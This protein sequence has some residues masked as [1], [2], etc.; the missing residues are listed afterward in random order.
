MNIRFYNGKILRTK[1][2]H[3][4][5]I[6]EGE[7]WVK[8]NKI[9]YLGDGKDLDG[10]YQR[11]DEPFIIW[12]REIDAR[13]YVI[14]PG[15]KN[16]HTHSAMTFLRSFADDMPLKDWLYNQIFPREAKLMPGDIRH[17]CKLG[18][19]EYLTSGIT[20]NFDMYLNPMEI[21][22]ASAECGFRTVQT[23]GLNDFTRSL[24][25]L[26]EDYRIVNEMSE[27]TTFLLGFHG[28]YTTRREL[29]EG[30]AKLAEKLKSPVWLH[31]SE[32]EKE[33]KECRGRYGMTP[34][35]ITEALG[36]YAFGGGGY[37]CI[38]FEEKDFEIFRNRG[39][40]AVTNPSSNLKLASGTAPTAR[41]LEEGISMAIGTDGPASNNA[42][43]MFREMFLVTGLAKVRERDAAAV[44]AEEV[45]YMATAGGA[46][47]M[48][49]SDCDSLEEGKFADLILID[50][51]QPNMQPENDFVKN[52]VY[53]GSKSNVALTM[54][55]GRILYEKGEF[56]I[57]IDPK[58]VYAK[59]NE[60]IGRMK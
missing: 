43:D 23:S 60:I 30:V 48:E 44:P 12:D 38:Y 33:V 41:F 21:A 20:A 18:I 13:G 59:A 28:E 26:E 14:M 11:L 16:A 42:L 29:M 53:S 27:L 10:V 58:E 8:G 32:T 31:N 17:L 7:L 50:L 35:Q 55:N 57:G 3:S 5:E 24:S 45:L 25:L 36:M 9:V 34:T 40:T 49:L 2:N 6:S 4:F 19:M 47:A 46:R 54:V 52:I 15:F 1:E 39:L 56:F 22:E 37:H 51:N